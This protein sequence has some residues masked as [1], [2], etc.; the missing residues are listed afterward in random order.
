MDESIRKV[1]ILCISQL[2]FSKMLAANSLP[3][4]CGGAYT[5]IPVTLLL[6]RPVI[7]KKGTGHAVGRL[8]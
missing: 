6:Q 8:T 2:H 5:R 3:M 4:I 1:G 7:Q